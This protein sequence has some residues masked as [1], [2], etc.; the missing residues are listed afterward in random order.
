MDPKDFIDQSTGV[1]RRMREGY[2][3]YVPAALPPNL[4][5]DNK[6]CNLLSEADRALGALSG[7]GRQLPNPHLLIAPYTRREAVLSSKIEGTQA[8]L[9]DLFLFEAEPEEPP[10][11]PDVRE[12]LNYVEALEYGLK[13]VNELPISNRLAR[14]IHSSSAT[15]MSIIVDFWP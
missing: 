5:Y 13:R 8:E 6:L 11:V 14:E 2:W 4:N 7:A 10:R 15:A 3:A 9:D 1:V 12:V